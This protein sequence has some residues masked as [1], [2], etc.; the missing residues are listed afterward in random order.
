MN[1]RSEARTIFYHIAA[2]EFKAITETVRTIN[3]SIWY[4]A[5][6]TDPEE[7]SSGVGFVPRTRT[8]QL[9]KM[10]IEDRRG[11]R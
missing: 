4:H 11:N 9:D 1:E 10:L 5:D 3:G 7:A 6:A 2:A 8:I